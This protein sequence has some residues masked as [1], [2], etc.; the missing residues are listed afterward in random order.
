MSG[1]GSPLVEEAEE[2][3]NTRVLDLSHYDGVDNSQIVRVLD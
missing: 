1:K 3:T 2:D